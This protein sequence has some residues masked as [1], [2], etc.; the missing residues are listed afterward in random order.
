M[1]LQPDAA[2]DVKHKRKTRVTR[3]KQITNELSLGHLVQGI[4]A[5]AF[6]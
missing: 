1:S 2:W 6:I 4:L 5:A 3:S